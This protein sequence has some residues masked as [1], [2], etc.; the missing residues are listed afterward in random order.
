MNA[1]KIFLIKTS[2]VHFERLPFQP[3]PFSILVFVILTAHIH[4][5]FS[6]HFT[7]INYSAKIYKYRQTIISE[8]IV[9][10][11]KQWEAIPG[12]WGLHLQRRIHVHREQWPEYLRMLH[13]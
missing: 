13:Q 4:P 7:R 1:K 6:I 2:D 9:Q 5:W 12:V 11:L 8:V 10:E 3:L